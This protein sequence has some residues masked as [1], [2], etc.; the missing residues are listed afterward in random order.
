M[1]MRTYLMQRLAFLIPTVL[2]VAT[3]VFAI[4][5]AV[6]GDPVDVLLGE[7]AAAVDRQEMRSRLGLDRPL[8]VQ[9][10]HSMAAAAQG[11]L[12]RSVRSD[13][14]V[15]SLI[16]ERLPATLALGAA[17]TA[18]A[19]ALGLPLGA[20]AAARKGSGADHFALGASLAAVAIPGFCLGPALVLL[21]SVTLR[22]LPVAGA[23]SPAHLL[24]PALT[25]GAGMSG[26]L[27]R[28]TR[29]ALLETLSEDYVRTARAKGLS[30]SATLVRHAL[31]NALTPVLSVVGLQLGA[32]LG[33]SV[34][35][36]TIF[37]WPGL[38]RLLVEAIQARDYP[39]VQ[40][41]VLVIAVVYVLVNL[42]TDIAY[43]AVNPKMRDEALR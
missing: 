1:N 35:T 38:G 12:G 40:G 41:T 30:E 5:H 28:M 33:G 39:L 20:L 13:R 27:V 29:S 31:P 3:L 43:V 8:L 17:A 10:A 7:S 26:V 34:I 4:L 14:P 2:G 21:F 9:Y 24:L 36:E 6:P 11:D 42:A 19:L 23:G 15:A 22:W 18:A 25:L 37:A 16:A 32:V